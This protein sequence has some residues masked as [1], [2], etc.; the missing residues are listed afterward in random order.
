MGKYRKTISYIRRN[1]IRKTFFRILEQFETNAYFANYDKESKEKRASEQE[2]LQQAQISFGSNPLISIV[3]PLYNTPDRFLKE[4]IESII[5]QSYKNWEL[6]LADG[7]GKDYLKVC[8]A[9]Y[10]DERIRYLGLSENGGISVNTN[11]GLAEANGDVIVFMDHDDIVE[12]DA[13]YYIAEAL[14]KGALALYTDEDKTTGDGQ[15]FFEPN[16]KPDFN[17]DLLL[18]NN[19]ICHIFAVRSDI[20]KEVGGLDKAFDGAQDYDYI[21]RCVE[22]ISRKNKADKKYKGLE[23]YIYHIPRVLYHWRCSENS[24]ADNPESKLYAYRAGLRAVSE[25]IK[26]RG[27]S[28]RVIDTEHQGFY[29]IIYN[30]IFDRDEVGAICYNKSNL[31]KYTD[32]T[33]PYV[34][35]K[36]GKLYN[37]YSGLNLYYSGYCH[38]AKMQQDVDDAW[39]EYVIRREGCEDM[40]LNRLVDKYLLVFDPLM[41][42]EKA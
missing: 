17:Y 27:I 40:S 7:S 5:A 25:H 32:S 33:G 42:G 13:L 18:S 41:D 11:A 4:L 22:A 37:P 29:R 9:G 28:G 26:R 20:A 23:K 36:T 34:F 16:F 39:D 35:D 38:R 24:T 10:R 3:V 19:Y 15:R 8:A 30:N 12:P 2:L 1:G 6:I 31:K 21:L 14:D